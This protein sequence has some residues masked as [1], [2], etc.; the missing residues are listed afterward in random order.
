MQ[1]LPSIAR[2]RLMKALATHSRLMT[3][4]WLAGYMHESARSSYFR[5]KCGKLSALQ[6]VYGQQHNY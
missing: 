2:F 3:Q 1:C 4:D 5:R 6:Q